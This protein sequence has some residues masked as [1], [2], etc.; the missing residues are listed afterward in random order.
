MSHAAPA[1]VAPRSPADASELRAPIF[2][3]SSPPRSHRTGPRPPYGTQRLTAERDLAAWL[4]YP[5][6][7]SPT[8]VMRYQSAAHRLA[9]PLHILN[10]RP[11][12]CRMSVGRL[13]SPHRAQVHPSP[14]QRA[15]TQTG[16]PRRVGSLPSARGR[17][18][19]DGGV[20]VRTDKQSGL[21]QRQQASV[22]PYAPIIAPTL[23]PTF[24]R[25]SDSSQ[26]FPCLPL[27]NN[28]SASGIG[29]H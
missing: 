22:S 24:D 8:P 13:A 16:Q 12:R 23:L 15:A 20:V 6:G 17:W 19:P 18:L 27:H 25:S 9:Y 11:A 7:S 1:L 28:P 14:G 3:A 4:P 29:A 5:R 2:L 26:K 10:S 21:H